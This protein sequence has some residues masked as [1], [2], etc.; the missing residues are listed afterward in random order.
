[1]SET[2]AA[3]PG[4]RL[5]NVTLRYG[6]GERQFAYLAYPSDQ[7]SV[8]LVVWV[9]GGGFVAGSA[10]GGSSARVMDFFLANGFA[11]ASIEYR[12][13]PEVNWTQ[14][15]G[16]IVDGV[17][18]VYRYLEERNVKIGLS[19]YVGSS[20]GAIAGAVLLYAPP[21]SALD[22][23]HYFD[24]FIGFSGGYCASQAAPNPSGKAS[25]CNI[26]VN[27][28]MPFD[29]SGMHLHRRIPA[30]LVNG[31]YDYLLDGYAGRDNYNH[32]AACMAK[33]LGSNNVEVSVVNLPSGHSTIKWLIAGSPEVI[34]AL[35]GFLE[36]LGW[37]GSLASPSGLVAYW[38]FDEVRGRIVVDERGAAN[39]VIQGRV[40]RIAGI[41]REAL[42]FNGSGYVRFSRDTAS[43]LGSLRE[44]SISLWFKY[45]EPPNEQK[46][47]PIFYLGK[48]SEAGEDNMFIIEIGHA[49]PG[50]RKLYV[51]WVIG[52][53]PALCFD[54]GFNL[55]PGKW[56]HL[57]V[58]V[59]GEG[60]TAY[61]N[62]EELVNR[63]YNFGGPEQKLFLADIPAKESV[64]IGYGKTASS[65]TPHFLKYYGAIDEIR[66][67]SKPLT[68][69]EVRQLYLASHPRQG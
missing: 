41:R 45:E 28:M 62:G 63:H 21:S 67:Y 32:Q 47:L 64:A 55:Q 33:W 59:G 15:L 19:I 36:R 39:G 65:I 46:V 11:V 6:S 42:L 4:G 68:S 3:V 26:T 58:V 5:V 12:L 31:I 56:Y 48:A 30:L 9:H 13:C 50:N 49:R 8:D 37:R 7:G 60:N 24:G 40:Y 44:G 53:R 66:I 20:A 57:V 61:L 52:G 17:E 38:S 18:T 23:S 16:D 69:Q 34:Q 27:E 29:K 2:S 10:L 51:T 14:L 1:M 22:L 35:Q 54:T 43:L 25:R